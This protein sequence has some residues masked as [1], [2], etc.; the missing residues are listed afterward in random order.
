[1]TPREFLQE[2]VLPN[3]DEFE[4]EPTSRRRAMNAV[5][6]V[7]ALPAH[8]YFWCKKLGPAAEVSDIHQPSNPDDHYRGKLS[9]EDGT[10]SYK[11]MRDLAKALKHVELTRGPGNAPSGIG[12]AEQV[13]EGWSS[14]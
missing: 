11:T 10:G 7:D 4:R 13:T 12:S 2:V 5:L 14:Q 1:M 8:I 9:R 6:S 3:M